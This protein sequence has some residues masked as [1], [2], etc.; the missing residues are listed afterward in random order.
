MLIRKLLMSIFLQIYPFPIPKLLSK[1]LIL[2]TIPSG[3]LG[4]ARVKVDGYRPS[5]KGQCK[6][7]YRWEH[8]FHR[9]S[10]GIHGHPRAAGVRE[11]Q[12]KYP[13]CMT[14]SIKVLPWLSWHDIYIVRLSGSACFVHTSFEF[15][16][17][18][19]FQYHHHS[20]PP[21]PKLVWLFSYNLSDQRISSKYLEEI[22]FMTQ[23]LYLLV[24][25]KISALC[26]FH[27]SEHSYD[28]TNIGTWNM[29]GS[30]RVNLTS[31]TISGI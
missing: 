5:W 19:F 12:M 11:C 22:L 4:H 14:E 8:S 23:P 13:D 15:A 21:L 2:T 24:I 28:S 30:P 3:S 27:K 6:L 18:F 29:N 7:G 20:A 17:M 31:S 9:A 1:P 16:P 10:A 25:L 26:C